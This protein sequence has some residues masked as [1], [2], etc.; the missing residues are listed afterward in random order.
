MGVEID[1]DVTVNW[2]MSEIKTNGVF[3]TD[4]NGLEIVKRATRIF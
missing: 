2:E 1:R 3:Y 4:S